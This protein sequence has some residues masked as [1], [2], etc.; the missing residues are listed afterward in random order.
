[1]F[2]VVIILS[3]FAFYKTIGYAIYEYKDNSNKMA[4][5][6]I[7]FLAIIALLGPIIVSAIK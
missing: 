5:T 6:I 3:V 1:M 4:G 2:F 7:G